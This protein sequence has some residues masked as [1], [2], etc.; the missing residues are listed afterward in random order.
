MQLFEKLSIDQTV[1][2]QKLNEMEQKVGRCDNTSMYMQ[3]M[4]DLPNKH[5]H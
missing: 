4:Y 3:K 5:S 1:V 2:V